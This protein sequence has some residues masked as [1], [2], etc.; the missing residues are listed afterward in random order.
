MAIF[1]E[2]IKLVKKL[3][4]ESEWF[5][6]NNSEYKFEFEIGFPNDNEIYV[7]HEYDDFC[8]FYVYPIIQMIRDYELRYIESDEVFKNEYLHG[9]CEEG[10][11]ILEDF[12]KNPKVRLFF[13]ENSRFI[14][15]EG[16]AF[17][18]CL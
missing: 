2:A 16:H 1:M 5:N 13:I 7:C 10:K 12:K 8:S 6:V 14:E 4:V 9:Y 3:F 11:D 15:Y 18:I 17:R